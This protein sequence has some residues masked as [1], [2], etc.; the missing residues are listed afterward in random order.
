MFYAKILNNQVIKYPCDIEDA[1]IGETVE[2]QYTPWPANT[3]EENVVFN[4][5]ECIENAWKVTWKIEPA[6][7]LQIQKRQAGQAQ[8]ASMTFEELA[9]L[10]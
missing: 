6:S 9:T 10:P 1:S 4:G 8:I 5:I 2:V 3:I 7:E